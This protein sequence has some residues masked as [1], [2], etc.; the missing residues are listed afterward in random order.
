VYGQTADKA[1][2]QACPAAQDG[3]RLEGTHA[4]G[5]ISAYRAGLAVADDLDHEQTGG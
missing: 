4:G 3:W 1:A 2:K 5:E